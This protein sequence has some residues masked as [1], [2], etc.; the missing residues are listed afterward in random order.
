[1]WFIEGDV[2][3]VEH[4]ELTR[5]KAW[6]VCFDVTDYTGSI[7][8]NKFMDGEEAQPIIK[9]VKDKQHLKIQGSLVMSRYEGKW[10]WSPWESW[11]PK[12]RSGRIK[13][14]RGTSG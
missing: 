5:R 12:R 6:V 14:R 4:K 13:P 2:F 9:G 11:R 7:R 8:V 1:M 10:C 3:N